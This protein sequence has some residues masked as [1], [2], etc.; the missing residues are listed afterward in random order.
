MSEA[1][2]WKDFLQ[3][4]GKWPPSLTIPPSWPPI[5]TA[6]VLHVFFV[7]MAFHM[8]RQPTRDASF[9]LYRMACQ[10]PP[11]RARFTRKKPLL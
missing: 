10:P 1:I 3:T 9:R 2:A 7:R 6:H 11:L 4:S 8:L 5:P